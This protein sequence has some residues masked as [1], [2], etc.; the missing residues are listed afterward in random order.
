MHGSDNGNLRGVLVVIALSC[1]LMCSACGTFSSTIYSSHT[2]NLTSIQISAASSTVP[3]GTSEAL[4]VTGTYSD[5]STADLTSRVT[6]TSSDSHIA[7]VNTDG[8]VAGV[9]LGTVTITA[10]KDSLSSSISITVGR[11]VLSRIYITPSE[12]SLPANTTLQLVALGTFSD[13]TSRE[14]NDLVTWAGSD[15]TKLTVSSDGT[16][17]SLSSGTVAVTATAIAGTISASVNVNVTT[18]QLVRLA[19]LPYQPV[20]GVGVLQ[21]FSALGTFDDYTTSELVSVSWNSSNSSVATIASDGKATPLKSGATTITATAGAIHGS[22]VLTI[23]PATLLSVTVDPAVASIAAGTNQQFVAHGMLSDGSV[24]DLPAA[25]WKSTDGSVAS[26]DTNGLSLAVAPGTVSVSA[27]IGGVTGSSTLKIT[28]AALKLIAVA[29][30][31]PIVPIL[32]MKQLYAVGE[33]SDGSVQDITNVANWWTSNANTVTVN[34]TGLSNTFNKGIVTISA[35]LGSVW[36]STTLQVSSVTVDSLEVTPSTSTLPEGAKFQY[37]LLSHLSD[38]ST[39]SLDAPHWSTSPITMAT[40]SPTGLVTARTATIGKL[41]G[42]TCCETTY[43]QLTVTNAQATSLSIKVDD[44]SVPTGALQP[45]HAVATFDDSTVLD[46][47]NAVHWTSSNPTVAV[48]D[49]DGNATA[50]SSGTTMIT[51]MFG[52]V[53]GRTDTVLA[54]TTLTVVQGSLTALTIMPANTSIPLG[55]SK[56]LTALGTFSDSSTHSVPELTWQSSDPAVAVVLPSGLVISTGQGSAVITAIS[57]SVQT[58][59]SV[60]VE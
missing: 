24:V 57:G 56:S 39:T 31:V 44:A 23:L 41:Y 36:G 6:W 17:T 25:D 30:A 18:A 8:G 7:T 9:S 58:A 53:D 2:P 3:E 15:N 50:K 14:V 54:T 22:V 1:C 49:G 5:K 60:T 4:T 32:A 38:G 27:T 12:P 45:L 43:I 21:K 13:G 26:V 47:S 55:Q 34:K 10:S 20:T 42:E 48:V 51:A 11:A 28:N 16:V 37:S 35:S 46:V 33:F 59:A 19:V 52:P 40:V 29:P